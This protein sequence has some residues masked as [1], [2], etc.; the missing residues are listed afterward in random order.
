M[1]QYSLILTRKLAI[2]NWNIGNSE[3][4]RSQFPICWEFQLIGLVILISG[5]SEVV[6]IKTLKY[7]I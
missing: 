3:C 7:L 5:N 6:P 4:F 2:L 1:Y